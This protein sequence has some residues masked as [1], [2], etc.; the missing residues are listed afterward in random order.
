[1]TAYALFMWV[2][3]EEAK[4]PDTP[5]TPPPAF[6]SLSH[7]PQRAFGM[8]N[9]AASIISDPLD[10]AVLDERPMDQETPTP[11]LSAEDMNKKNLLLPEVAT[12]GKGDDPH[13][14]PAKTYVL[15]LHLSFGCF[16]VRWY[17]DVL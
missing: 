2:Q 8:N 5:P 1:M 9:P 14:P 16:R 13:P 11:Q 15:S 4:K 17:R 7:Y 10:G 12:L 6:A 3:W